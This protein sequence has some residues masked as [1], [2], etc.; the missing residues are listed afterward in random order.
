MEPGQ[1]A[2]RLIEPAQSAVV[3]EKFRN[4][5]LCNEAEPNSHQRNRGRE[6]RQAGARPLN[7]ADEE[8]PRRLRADAEEPQTVQERTFAR[9]E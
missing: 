1:L 3:A 7:H 9:G 4:V 5:N 6:P 2:E 8:M